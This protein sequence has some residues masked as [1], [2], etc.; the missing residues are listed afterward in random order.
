MLIQP[1]VENSLKHGGV[2]EDKDGYI[3]ISTYAD[4]G[5]VGDRRGG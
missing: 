4:G 5:D 2:M 3:S 1:I